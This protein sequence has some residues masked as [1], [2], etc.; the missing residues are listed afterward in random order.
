VDKPPEIGLATREVVDN[1]VAV[2]TAG[3]IE[4]ILPEGATNI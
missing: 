1:R 3:R 4:L 2:T